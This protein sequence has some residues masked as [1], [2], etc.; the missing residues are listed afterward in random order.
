MAV[1]KR[2]ETVDGFES[3]IGTNHIGHSYLVL[4][5]GPH[6]KHASRVVAVS[7]L[8]HRRSGVVFD[9]PMLLKAYDPW[10]AYG[11]SKSANILMALQLQ[12]ILG[13]RGI[14]AFSLHPG[15]IFTGLQKH[16]TRE[17][18]I[19]M[20]WYKEDGKTPIDIFKDV[21]QGAS[22]TIYAA[23]HRPLAAKGG[24]YLEDCHVAE[25]TPPSRFSKEDA[26]KLWG[27]TLGWLNEKGF[28][29]YD[30]AFWAGNAK[31]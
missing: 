2:E 30:Q 4:L 20:G 21:P 7:S 16:M 27:L 29:D 31:M 8:G 9:D 19:A 23:L 11:Q 14:S 24:S 1:R 17:E 5:L 6:L 12:Q 22:T 25:T 13:P 15:A 3:Q 28:G 26:A 18:E 10:K